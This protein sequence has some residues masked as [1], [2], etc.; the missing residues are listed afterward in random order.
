MYI[1]KPAQILFAEDIVQ[2]FAVASHS[3]THQW[4]NKWSCDWNIACLIPQT[5]VIEFGWDE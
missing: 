5:I 4:L 2:R 1:Y 3:P